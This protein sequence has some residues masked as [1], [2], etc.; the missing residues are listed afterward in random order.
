MAKR[1][2]KEDT[3]KE[4]KPKKLSPFDFLNSIN[5]TK[6]DLIV[7]AETE[8]AY[9]SFMINRGLS[10]FQDTVLL[11]NEMN[12]LYHLPNKMQYDFLRSTI[13][14]GKRFSKWYKAEEDLKIDVIKEFYGYSTAKAAAVVNLITDDDISQMKSLMNKGGVK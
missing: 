8:K 7:D 10:Y 12:C 3:P 9:V 6:V 11:A 4:E 14:N 5:A 13:R 1:K 2:P